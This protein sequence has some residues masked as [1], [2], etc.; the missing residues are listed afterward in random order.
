MA[1]VSANLHKVL[2]LGAANSMWHYVDSAADGAA[3]VDTSGY[4]NSAYRRL[5]VGDLILRVTPSG[6]TN[7]VVTGVTTMGFHVVSSNASGVV[8]VND[9]LALTMTDTD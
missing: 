3:A 8:D 1:F 9:V 5:R 6:I 2:D 4:F 7:G